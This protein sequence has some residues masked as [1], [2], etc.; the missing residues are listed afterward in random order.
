LLP[1]AAPLEAG[2][3]S[4]AGA[5]DA[6]LP[7]HQ[8]DLVFYGPDGSQY[9]SSFFDATAPTAAA[10][11][12]FETALGGDRALQGWIA[13]DLV[14]GK[15]FDQVKVARVESS[16]LPDALVQCVT[17]AL[18]SVTAQ[19]TPEGARAYVA[20]RS[21]PAVAPPA[22]GERTRAAVA[23]TGSDVD[24]DAVFASGSCGVDEVP[25]APAVVDASSLE[26]SAARGRVGRDDDAGSV[27][28]TVTNRTGSPVTLEL[29]A[30]ACEPPVSLAVRYPHG[31]PSLRVAMPCTIPRPGGPLLVG[32]TVR[33]SL[34]RT[35]RVVLAPHGVARATATW[36][37]WDYIW[38]DEA[39]SCPEQ[40][41]RLSPGAYTAEVRLAQLA[42][43]A[44]GGAGARLTAKTVIQVVP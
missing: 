15:Q 27:L 43:G 22:T 2:P 21:G 36:T 23:C 11:V 42:G 8:L 12:C 14:R 26:L 41:S 25:A 29:Q 3:A 6:P 38:R 5:P 37:P 16:P 39:Q 32:C 1:A 4:D 13:A 10:R 35:R 19:F 24:L 18:E 7:E 44:D 34:P 28:V 33:D 20:M 40:M 30:H 17:T 9:G 31:G